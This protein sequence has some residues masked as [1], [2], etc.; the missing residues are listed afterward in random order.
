MIFGI[1]FFIN[2]WNR[3]SSSKSVVFIR[4][5]E[6]YIPRSSYLSGRLWDLGAGTSSLYPI[7]SMARTSFNTLEF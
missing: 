6:L 1:I 5:Y 7:T 2:L 4:Y 3:F